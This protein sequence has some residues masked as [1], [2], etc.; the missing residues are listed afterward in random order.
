M[1]FTHTISTIC[2]GVIGIFTYVLPA[3]ANNNTPKS[4]EAVTMETPA[5]ALTVKDLNEANL[6]S[7]AI[8]QVL[9]KITAESINSA[10]PIGEER[11]FFQGRV[12]VRVYKCWKAPSEEKP[13]NKALLEIYESKDKQHKLLFR[14]WMLT[15]N[16]GV[17]S[18]EHPLYDITLVECSNNDTETGF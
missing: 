18:L 4:A 9:D 7:Y 14:G 10:L 6:T 5:P 8:V 13:E 12:S 16:S 17:S 1:S 15:S 3:Y 2:W 11:E